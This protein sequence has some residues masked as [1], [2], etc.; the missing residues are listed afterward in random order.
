MIKV[1]FK[2][3][4]RFSNINHMVNSIFAQNTHSLMSKRPFADVLGVA[5]ATVYTYLPDAKVNP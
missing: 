1:D 2:L 4:E 3:I 5:R